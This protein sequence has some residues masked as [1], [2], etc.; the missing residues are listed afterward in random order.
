MAQCPHGRAAMQGRSCLPSPRSHSPAA[1]QLE[2]CECDVWQPPPPPPGSLTAVTLTSHGRGGPHRRARGVQCCAR[3]LHACVAS[4]LLVRACTCTPANGHSCMCVSTCVRARTR[5]CLCMLSCTFA[6]GLSR[7]ALGAHVCERRGGGDGS[8]LLM[9]TR[10]CMRR[11]TAGKGGHVPPPPPHTARLG[12]DANEAPN[13]IKSGERWGGVGGGVR[14]QGAHRGIWERGDAALRPPGGA[15]GAP[16]LSPCCPT[17]PM[18]P[19]GPTAGDS[20]CGVTAL[21]PPVLLQRTSLLLDLK[22]L[23]E[24]VQPAATTSTCNPPRPCTSTCSPAQLRTALW[25]LAPP[26]VASCS[27]ARPCTPVHAAPGAASGRAVRPL[28]ALISANEAEGCQGAGG[29]RSRQEAATAAF[30]ISP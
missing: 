25:S 4:Y 13:L 2:S 17:A 23:H 16:M 3:A 15:G 19:R 9:R 12:E 30:L 21:S 24:D 20:P 28:P 27:L 7:A 22:A 10:V 5:V 26:H 1:L 11:H 29:R 8:A 6:G 18:A 14:D